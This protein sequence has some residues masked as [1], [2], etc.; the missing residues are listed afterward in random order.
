MQL[1]K[2][3]AILHS[4]KSSHCDFK[5]LPKSMNLK[6][7]TASKVVSAD[8]HQSLNNSVALYD[9]VQ[10]LCRI[11]ILLGTTSGNISND[12]YITSTSYSSSR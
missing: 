4:G 3:R 7:L 2:S 1:P 12:T 10:N 5:S 9:K 6:S 11:K 8:Q